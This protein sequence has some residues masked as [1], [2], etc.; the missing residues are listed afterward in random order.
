MKFT[1][2]TAKEYKRRQ[3]EKWHKWFAWYF[4]TIKV[5]NETGAK[6]RLIFEPVYRKWC[7]LEVELDVWGWR[8]LEINDENTHAI[9]FNDD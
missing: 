4:V 9:G 3:K 6:D 2:G 8:Y 7:W 5:D 1:Y